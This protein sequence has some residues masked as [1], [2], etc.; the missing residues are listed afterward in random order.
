MTTETQQQND[1][2]RVTMLYALANGDATV[3]QR[4]AEIL[5]Q[6]LHDLVARRIEE[7]DNQY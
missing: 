7:R 1:I 4:Q 3:S 6:D 2:N 5:L